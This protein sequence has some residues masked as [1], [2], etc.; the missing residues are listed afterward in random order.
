MVNLHQLAKL[1]RLE[2]DIEVDISY[3]VSYLGLVVELT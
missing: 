3:L 2:M 1:N